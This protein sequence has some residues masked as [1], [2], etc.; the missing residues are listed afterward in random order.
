[1]SPRA[2]R[3]L[4]F[5]FIAGFLVSAPALVLYTA[6]YRLNLQRGRFV[7][8]GALSIDSVP[9]G[10]PILIDGVSIGQVTPAFIDAVLPGPRHITLQKD[11]YLPWEKTLDVQS[12]ETTFV[13][14]A[15]I[16]PDAASVRVRE[17]PLDAVSF[18]RVSAKAAYV[19]HEKG[20]DEV[21]TYDP[22]DG[23]ERLV[24]RL[25]AP[26]ARPLVLTWSV[27]GSE[28]LVNAPPVA[29]SPE[30][31]FN[32]EVPAHVW[33]WEPNGRRLL[34]TD[35]FELH[36]FDPLDQSDE[37]L[38]RV[39]DP[40]TGLAWRPGLPAVLYA[41]A[42]R[43]TGLELDRRD[44]RLATLIVQGTHLGN[45]WTDTR[46]RTAYFFGTIEGKTGLFARPL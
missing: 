19:R 21:W 29:S 35:G 45:L 3:L 33:Q 26:H 36:L 25:S 38:T 43:I 41:Q 11:G 44:N 42:T 6:G 27:D 32:L 8:T 1:M 37:T 5:L 24:A 22:L 16:T 31:I 15:V 34:Y 2:R 39:S 23:E 18:S 28:S 40:I 10:V 30:L 4:A 13:V 9:R 12:R 17:T 7:Q 20:W 14:D 46:G